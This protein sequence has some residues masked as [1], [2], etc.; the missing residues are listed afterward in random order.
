MRRSDSPLEAV[1]DPPRS[2]YTLVVL[3][4]VRSAAVHGLEAY[5]V[6]VEVDVGRGLPSFVIVGLPDEAV[7]ESKERV[8]AAIRNAGYDVPARRITVN[9]APADVRKAGPSFDLPIAV[10][11]LTATA[12]VRPHGLPDSMLLGELSLD[13]TLPPITRTL[14]VALAAPTP[15]INA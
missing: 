5:P 8:R 15:R 14:P 11:V 7:Q 2:S 9:L 1:P 13:G 3:A 4:R 12:Q 10:G 6:D